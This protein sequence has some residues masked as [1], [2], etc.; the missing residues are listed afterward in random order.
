MHLHLGEN[1]DP[2]VLD[3]MI[4]FL[5]RQGAQ[6]KNI[7]IVGQSFNEIPIEVSAGKS[8][9]LEVAEK[10]KVSLLD[11]SKTEFT[12]QSSNNFNFWLSAELFKQDL[13][14]NLP[15]LNLHPKLGVAGATE[16]VFK[17]LDKR[18]YLAL[19]YLFA[20]EQIF[21]KIYKALPKNI[22][23]IGEAM[24][25]QKT[26]KLTAF[27]SIVLSGHNMLNIDRV[28]AEICMLSPLPNY[29][30]SIKMENIPLTGREIEEVQFNVESI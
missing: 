28:F 15:T 23:T 5:I 1:T 11:L 9:F 14:I 30:R 19:K 7:K 29:M 2:R 22:L 8:R 6:A 26:N 17:F 25:V 24:S 4:K 27:L 21:S 13:I 3:A 16:N 12:K 10:N 18:S 20:N